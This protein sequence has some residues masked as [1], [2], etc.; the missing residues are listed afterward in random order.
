MA[1][2]M[3]SSVEQVLARIGSAKVHGAS[4]RWEVV[5]A[6]DISAESRPVAIIRN[7]PDPERSI[8]HSDA[9]AVT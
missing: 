3:E 8:L 4:S 6:E 7:K 5:R 9:C 1:D 2:L